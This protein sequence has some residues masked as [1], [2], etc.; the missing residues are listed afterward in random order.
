MT[1]ELERILDESYLA[2]IGSVTIEAVRAKRAECQAV[3][4]GLSYLR[5]LAQGRLDVMAVEL[6]RR[7][8]GRAAS[9]LAQLVENLPS[10][11]ADRTRSPGIGRMSTTL[12]PGDAVPDLTV[13][14]AEI[15]SGCDIDTLPTLGN[16]EIEASR[17][18]LSGFEQRISATRREVLDR[19]DA[20]QAE[21]TRR[22]RT[23]E[24]SVESLLR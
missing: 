11:L 14:L 21:L 7:R 13:E 15:V 22:Y 3:E 4:T 2:G 16:D 17:A 20:L 8:E 5:R 19:V 23:G 12:D 10:T 6:G 1:S 9:D 18:N 24:A